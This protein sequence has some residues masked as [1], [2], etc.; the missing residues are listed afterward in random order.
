MARLT[1]T[2]SRYIDQ[3]FAALPRKL[4]NKILRDEIKVL[5]KQIAATAQAKAPVDE[6]DL[7]RAIRVRAM[8]RKRGFVGQSVM[9]IAKFMP[10]T[11]DGEIADR[12]AGSFQEY[13]TEHQPAQPFMRPAFEQHRDSG[14]ASVLSRVK[15]RILAEAS[16]KG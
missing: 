16:R 2:G 1:L 7:R 8:R 15:Q 10:R 3:V 4:Q 6:G 13:G 9:T 12:T 14:K 5:A 11:G